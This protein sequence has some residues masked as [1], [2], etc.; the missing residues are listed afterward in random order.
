MGG[1]VVLSSS[2][3]NKFPMDVISILWCFRG[4][5]AFRP[6]DPIATIVKWFPDKRGLMTA[7]GIW[8]RRDPGFRPISYKV[9]C[10]LRCFE[11]LCYPGNNI[12]V[13][14]RLYTILKNQTDW[15]PAVWPGCGDPKQWLRATTPRGNVQDSAFLILGPCIFS[16]SQEV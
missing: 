8:F 9:D 3:Q 5:V 11:C 1:T 12:L 7:G 16:V 4:R 13:A 14:G 15:A 6:R 2:Q 10:G